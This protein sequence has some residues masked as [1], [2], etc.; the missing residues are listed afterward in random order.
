[1][2]DDGMEIVRGS[3]NVY[4]DL[5]MAEPDLRQTKAILAAEII[6]SVDEQGWTVRAAHE[7]T[8]VPAADFSRLRNAN[9]AR[10]TIERLVNILGRLDREV[11]MSVAVKPRMAHAE[12][13]LPA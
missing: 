4:R 8:G 12:S 6:K 1:M 7:A 2:K 10:F 9:L 11:E 13:G 5:G 3:G